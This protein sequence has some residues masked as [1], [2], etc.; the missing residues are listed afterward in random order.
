MNRA[1]LAQY[2]DSL[3]FPWPVY[4]LTG[5]LPSEEYCLEEH[6][7]GFRI[8]YSERG[9]RNSETFYPTEGEACRGLIEMM[10]RDTTLATYLVNL[11]TA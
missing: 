4:C 1:E 10:R 11:P 6:E 5:G 9:H 3:N 7:G 8:Y 2:L